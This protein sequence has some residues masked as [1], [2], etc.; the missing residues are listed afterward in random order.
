[1]RFL[2]DYKNLNTINDMSIM[3][4]TNILSSMSATA[5]SDTKVFITYLNNNY[6]HGAVT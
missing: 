2:N 4:N 6:L 3:T 1:M 5:L